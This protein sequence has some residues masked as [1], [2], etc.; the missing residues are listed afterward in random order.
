MTLRPGTSRFQPGR[1]LLDITY[2]QSSTSPALAALKQFYAAEERY[3]PSGGEDFGA[4]AAAVHPDILVVTPASLPY[5]G[6]WRGVE[7]F[8]RFLQAFAAAWKDLEVSDPTIVEFGG[9]AVIVLLTMPAKA[10][11]RVR[12][13]GP[14]C[15]S[16]T[17]SATGCLPRYAPSTG[18]RQK[19][20]AFSDTA[21]AK[22]GPAEGDHA[23]RAV[24]S[25]R[26]LVDTRAATY[27]G[28]A[29]TA[30]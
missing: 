26:T 7:G 10:A 14:R 1:R 19:R 2:T 16:S 22:C 8:E 21:R 17:G 24:P 27:A 20:A 30:G 6:E 5:G 9:D 4:V 23:G 13:C 15:V 29:G 11:R 12:R 3:V 28:C 18:T 25:P